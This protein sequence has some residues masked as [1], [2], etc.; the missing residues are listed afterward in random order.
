[1]TP[2][3]DVASIEAAIVAHPWRGIGLAFAAGVGLALLEPR[4]RVA[5]AA[6]SAIGTLVLAAIRE[7][8]RERVVTHAKTWAEAAPSAVGDHG[9]S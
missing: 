4:G 6:G 1:M 5:R 9:P 8:A 2:A 3:F 7:L